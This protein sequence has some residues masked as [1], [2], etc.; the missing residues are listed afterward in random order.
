MITY[1]TNT[2]VKGLLGVSEPLIL[3][4]SGPSQL[5][6]T[7]QPALSSQLLQRPSNP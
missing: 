7:F 5:P 3:L 2:F 6:D 4:L 1:R